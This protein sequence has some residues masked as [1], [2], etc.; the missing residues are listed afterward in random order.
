MMRTAFVFAVAIAISA[1]GAAQQAAGNVTPGA[2]ELAAQVAGAM[3]P[4]EQFR[5]FLLRTVASTM[6]GRMIIE[7]LGVDGA[8]ALLTAEVDRAVLAHGDQWEANLAQSYR[9]ALTPEELAEAK[10][11]ID[12]RDQAAM[13]PLM[14]K[15]GPAMQGKSMPL[16][17]KASTETLTRAFAALDKTP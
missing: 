1:P 10:R 5:G 15:V 13:L 11:A 8:R 9:E 16:L 7:K 2:A 14:N 4:R 17:E 3:A 6:T 12:A